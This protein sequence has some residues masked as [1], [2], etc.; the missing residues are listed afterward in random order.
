MEAAL[1]REA[2]QQAAQTARSRRT[3]RRAAE[4]GTSNQADGPAYDAGFGNPR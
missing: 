2:E 4:R 3:G 1:R